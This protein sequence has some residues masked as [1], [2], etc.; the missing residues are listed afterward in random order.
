[1][2]I[3]ERFVLNSAVVEVQYLRGMVFFDKCGSLMDRLS[4]ALGPAFEIW[5]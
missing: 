4:E 3:A 5:K 2:A 1:M